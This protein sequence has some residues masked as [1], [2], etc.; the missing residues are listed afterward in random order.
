LKLI[1]NGEGR[2]FAASISLQ[3]LIQSL[4][5]KRETVVAEVN[6]SVV[7][8]ACH[9]ETLLSEGDRVELIQF[10]GGG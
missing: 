1:V 8:P 9:G 3:D 10:V 2:E 7:Q 5:L 4:G 6:L